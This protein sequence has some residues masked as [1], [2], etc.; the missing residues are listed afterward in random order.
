MYGL[1]GKDQPDLYSGRSLLLV[2]QP[3]S[4]EQCCSLR[5]PVMCLLWRPA[6]AV[7]RYMG[8]LSSGVT[9]AC[10]RQ[11]CQLCLYAFVITLFHQGV[12]WGVGER[13]GESFCVQ[14]TCVLGTMP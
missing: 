3:G 10:A 6:V 9:C 4:F 13:V 1:H 7:C 14:D 12:G 8:Q 5:G 2:E 11:A